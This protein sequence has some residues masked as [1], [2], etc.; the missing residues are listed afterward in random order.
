MVQPYNQVPTP[1]RRTSE[2]A[3]YPQVDTAQPYQRLELVVPDV[4]VV[5]YLLRQPDRLTLRRAPADM[6]SDAQAQ[7]YWWHGFRLNLTQ[8]IEDGDTMDEFW[9]TA[10]Q[11]WAAGRTVTIS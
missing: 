3:A 7:A 9:Q 2:P 6:V 1:W 5:A 4:G 11:S 8:A 10:S